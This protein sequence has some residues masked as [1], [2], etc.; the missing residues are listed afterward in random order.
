MKKISLLLL[1]AASSL[2]FAQ[3]HFGV[4]AGYIN[5]SLHFKDSPDTFWE[6]YSELKSNS[7]FYA[8]GFAEHFI[9]QKFALQGELLF[10]QIGAKTNVD[11]YDLVGNEIIQG[12]TMK[13]TYKYTQLQVPISAKYYFVDQFALSGGFT[14]AFNIDAQMKNDANFPAFSSGKIENAR[15]LNVNPF[16]G[17]EYHITQNIFADARYN[18]G[19]GYINNEGADMRSSFFQIGLGY[20]FK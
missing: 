10:T 12:G 5:S 9:N 13:V 6:D 16:L 3:T 18:F 11:L 15:T 19:F 20:R 8:G 2:A 14:F 1:I 7:F 4:K 17:A